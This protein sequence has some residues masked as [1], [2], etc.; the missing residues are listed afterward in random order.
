[1]TRKDFVL[2][3]FCIAQSHI[4]DNARWELA[5]TFAHMLPSTNPRFDRAKFIAACVTDTWKETD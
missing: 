3:A 4:S 5:H 1:M 2:I